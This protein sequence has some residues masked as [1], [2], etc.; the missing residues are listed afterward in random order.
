MTFL[1]NLTMFSDVVNTHSTERVLRCASLL[2]F[3]GFLL[4][5][6]TRQTLL[7][8]GTKGSAKELPAEEQVQPKMS[9]RSSS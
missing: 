5:I 3:P 1:C 8:A 6:F 7:E 4:N 9:S 2:V